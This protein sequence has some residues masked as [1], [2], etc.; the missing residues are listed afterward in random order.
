MA[1]AVL[2]LDA[3]GSRHAGRSGPLTTG[4]EVFV[5]DV[6]AAMTT[7]PWPTSTTSTRSRG[8][9]SSPVRFGVG[10]LFII[11]PSVRAPYNEWHLRRPWRVGLPAGERLDVLVPDSQA[12]N[13]T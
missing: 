6:M 2:P 10:R 4:F 5:H 9:P 11:S 12:V 8:P 7:W 3:Q 1:A 13:V